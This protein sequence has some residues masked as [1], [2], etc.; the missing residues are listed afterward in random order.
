MNQKFPVLFFSFVKFL[1]QVL[2]DGTSPSTFNL[3]PSVDA[4]FGFKI[5]EL[6]F[7]KKW[8]DMTRK[9]LAGLFPDWIVVEPDLN[10][11]MSRTEFTRRSPQEQEE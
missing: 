1:L 4:F 3:G 10:T 7:R 8:N 11:I 6:S 5:M 2:F 9:K